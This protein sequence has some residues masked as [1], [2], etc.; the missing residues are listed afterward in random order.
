MKAKIALGAVLVA[1]IAAFF[2]FDLQQ[3]FSL[4]YLKSQKDALNNLYAEKP[5]LIAGAFFLT[6]VLFAALALPAALI[7]T[8][9]GGA[10]F[11]F[12]TG[13]FLVSFASTIGATF[14][15]IF[16]RFLFHDAIEAKFGDRL[17]AVNK[18][19]EAE[20]AFYVFGLRLVPIF[21]FF[22]VNSLLAL[23]KLRV[24]T[25]YW[26]SQLGMLAGTAVY[27]NAGTRIAE[28]ERTSD[29]ASPQLIA[30]F[31][32]LGVFPLLAK[33]ALNLLKPKST[34]DNQEEKHG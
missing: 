19:V 22:V 28:I 7:L 26:A 6:Y 13:L 31:I 5:V 33:K 30:S 2:I 16:T 23:T 34:V 11:G 32:L 18:G 12:W 24:W 27:V 4:D 10:I 1:L 21:P 8:L 25:F 17:A 20:G 15:F 3:Y 29:I 9:S 14:A